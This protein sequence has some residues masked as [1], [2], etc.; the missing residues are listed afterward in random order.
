MPT[1]GRFRSGPRGGVACDADLEAVAAL[2]ARPLKPGSWRCRPSD[3]SAP[4]R[5]EASLAMPT[6][7]PW[8]LC[9]HGRLN[10]AVEAPTPRRFGSGPRGGVACDAGL[11]AVAAL[12]SRP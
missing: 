9:R 8:R 10:R 4:D 7:R 3:D 12:P 6:W 5:A 11:A 2:P 1:L